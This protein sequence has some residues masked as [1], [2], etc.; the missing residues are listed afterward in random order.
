VVTAHPGLAAAGPGGAGLRTY[1]ELS[2]ASNHAEPCR[3]PD[4]VPLAE[5]EMFAAK[6]AGV[7]RFTLK[8]QTKKN[9]FQR[10]QGWVTARAARTRPQSM[11]PSRVLQA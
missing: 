2:C 1:S 8:K 9:A 10:W 5:V 11:G 3:L 4:F 6:G 7:S